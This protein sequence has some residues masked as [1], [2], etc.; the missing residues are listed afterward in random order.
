MSATT[1]IDKDVSL[2]I[3][4]YVPVRQGAENRPPE[5][6]MRRPR[7][8][9]TARLNMS[10][11]VLTVVPPVVLA[12]ILLVSWYASTASGHVSSLFLPAPGD[13]LSSLSD[14]ISN[15]I[16]LSNNLFTV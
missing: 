9:R 16:Y 14:N 7:R 11:R 8:V 10:N 5:E 4:R 3:R 6:R 2:E 12:V 1:S 15:G 13:V